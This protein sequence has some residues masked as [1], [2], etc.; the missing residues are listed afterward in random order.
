[1]LI[2]TQI[3]ASV[4]SRSLR[5]LYSG[6]LLSFVLVPHLG[7]RSAAAAKA[8]TSPVPQS[9]ASQVRQPVLVELFTSEGC[10]DCPPADELLA[11][12]DATQ[13]VPSAHV[14]VLSEHVTYWNHD[15]WVDPY[16]LDEMTQRQSWYVNRFHLD[17]AYTPQ[18]VV[19]GAAQVIGND[20]AALTHA[21][22]AA[23]QKTKPDLRIEG[24]SWDG[25]TIGF[26]VKAPEG[27]RGVLSVALAEDAT[28]SAVGRGENAG[29]TL[30]HVA[31]VRLMKTMGRS[32]TDE[33][34]LTLQLGEAK[35]LTGHAYR[36]IVFVTDDEGGRVLAAAEV[37]I[38]RP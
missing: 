27:L 13:F 22:S 9:D 29:R 32:K 3:S 36:L 5:F 25:D 10:S 8:S 38:N 33:K 4:Q 1:M 30:H 14:I 7:N 34:P 15:G 26:A 6:L 20:G 31:V 16:S 21:I 11:R 24:A 37:A 18:A 17:S 28:S 35:T 19:D 23:A 12:L 2:T